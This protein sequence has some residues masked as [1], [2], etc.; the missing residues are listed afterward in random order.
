MKEAPLLAPIAESNAGIP[1]GYDP[2]ISAIDY[3][4]FKKFFDNLGVELGQYGIR[5]NCISPFGVATPTVREGFGG[6]D[7][8]K[9]EEI[10]SAAANLKGTV[11]KA[12]DI[13]EVALYLASDEYK[14]VIGMNLAVDGD[15]NITNV[16]LEMT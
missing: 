16:S 14:Y 9:A 6:V 5:V 12:E 1:G 11:L 8:E 2:R 4:I 7:V 10:I 13:A 3:E 15:Y